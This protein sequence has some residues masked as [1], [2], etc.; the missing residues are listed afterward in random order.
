[1]TPSQL[2]IIFMG[3]PEFAVPSLRAL[4]DYGEK[5]VAVVTQPDRPK[6]RG[7]A[8]AAPPVKVLAQEAGIEL[9]QP[10]KVR[11]EEFLDQ[12]RAYRPDLILV[13]AY[14]RI[15]TPAVLSLPRLGCINVHGSLLPKYRGAAP[16]QTAI[17]RGEKEAGVTI[18]RMDAGLDTGDMLLK[19][20]LAITDQDTAATLIPRLA[21]LGGRLLIEA[22][23]RLAQG[24]LPPEKQDDSQATLAPPLTKEEGR[25][26]WA[27][28]ALAI[29]CRIRALDPWPMAYTTLQGKQ[30]KLFCPTVIAETAAESPGVIVRADRNGVVIAC[31]QGQLLVA[32]PTR[33]Q[34]KD[35]GPRL[36]PRLSPEGRRCTR[37]SR[38]APTA[39]GRRSPFS[40]ASPG[41]AAICSSGR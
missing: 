7:R 22:L 33:G 26:D 39:R 27:D 21:E 30:L 16:I 10:T 29:S 4:I 34:E 25:I 38:W 12:L 11:S 36:S 23:E 28:S 9:L 14:G 13:A 18:M 31:G 15:L 37:L 17:L 3:T 5:V 32:D 41:S 40:T 19:G 6:G 20:S 2:R 1:M 8:L 24:R 35:A